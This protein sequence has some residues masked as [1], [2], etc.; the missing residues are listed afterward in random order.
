MRM[1]TK[2]LN[3]YTYSNPAGDDVST[4]IRCV[5]SVHND[6]IQALVLEKRLAFG[7]LQGSKLRGAYSGRQSIRGHRHITWANYDLAI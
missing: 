6:S 1:L 2:A 7:T 5:S 3:R 4:F